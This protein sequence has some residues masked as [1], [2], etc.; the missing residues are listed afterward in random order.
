MKAMIEGIL[1]SILIG[2]QVGMTLVLVSVGLTLIFGMMDVINFA[3]GS[4]YMLGGYF[5]LIATDV[6][7][8]FWVALLVAPLAV[9]LIGLLIEVVFLRPLYGRGALFHILLTFGVLFIIR[10]IVIEIW[11][12]SLYNIPV[13]VILGGSTVLGPITYPTYRLFLLTISTLIVLGLWAVFRFTNIGNIMLACAYDD[14]M[15][16]TLGIRVSRVYT[17]VFVVGAILAGLAGFLMG[18]SA[19]VHPNMDIEII[20]L[21]FAIVIIGGMG[22]FRGAVIGGLLVGLIESYFGL[23]ASTWAAE[24]SIFILMAAI[25]LWRPQGLFG[26]EEVGT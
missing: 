5:G 19:S 4:L 9:G 22:S 14:E 25:L 10:G 26:T 17:G 23:F 18:A 7:G 15:V 16:N 24:M 12:R 11:S 3:H 13:P 21:A 20:I 2:L 6:F 8:N 1:R